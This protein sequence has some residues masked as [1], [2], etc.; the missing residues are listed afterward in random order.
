MHII[1]EHEWDCDNCTFRSN[2]PD[3]LRKHLKDTSHQPSITITNR[4]KLFED[5]KRC[6]TCDLEIDGYTQLMNHR[7]EVHPSN[8]KCRNFPLGKCIY[9]NGCWYVHAEDLMDVDESFQHTESK[10][11]CYICDKTF[12]TKDMMK[13]HK[14]SL[15]VKDV[16][17]CEKFNQNKCTRNSDRCWYRHEVPSSP[18]PVFQ[19]DHQQIFPR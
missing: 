15:H 8:R 12:E 19:K 6:Y 14:K 9:G 5:Y 10:I 13:K 2:K 11:K 16:Q 7:K 3:E 4:T 1:E 17:I 18:L